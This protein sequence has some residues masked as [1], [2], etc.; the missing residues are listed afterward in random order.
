MDY[1][2]FNNLM[3]LFDNGMTPNNYYKNARD[4]DKVGDD[5]FAEYLQIPEQNRRFKGMLKPSKHKPS[6]IGL[7]WNTY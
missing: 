5:I 7:E 1:D 3:L 2:L 4:N 6:Y